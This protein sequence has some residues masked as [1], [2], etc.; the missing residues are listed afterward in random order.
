[1]SIDGNVVYAMLWLCIVINLFTSYKNVRGWY[2][3]VRGWKKIK[4]EWE[5]V[6]ELSDLE[7][8]IIH[9]EAKFFESATK[10]NFEAAEHFIA[11]RNELHKFFSEKLQANSREIPDPKPQAKSE[12]IGVN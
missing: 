3:N 11:Q 2:K 7:I 4:K 1:M 8:A 5:L 12:E 6:R 9:N 10:R